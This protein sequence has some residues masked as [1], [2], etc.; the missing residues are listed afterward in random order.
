MQALSPFLLA[1]NLDVMT[2]SNIF[3]SLIYVFKC[4]SIVRFSE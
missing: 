2:S 3:N 4:K 1:I